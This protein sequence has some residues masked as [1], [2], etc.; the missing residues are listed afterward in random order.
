MVIGTAIEE[1]IVFKDDA[2]EHGAH[3]P[4]V[5]SIIIVLFVPLTPCTSDIA[6]QQ[7]TDAPHD[8]VYR[9]MNKAS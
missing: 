8:I 5:H 6:P 1:V 4:H 2:S 9:Y 7:F 3:C